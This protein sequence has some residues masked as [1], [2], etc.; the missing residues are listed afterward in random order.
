MLDGRLFLDLWLMDD[1]SAGHYHAY[2]PQRSEVIK[3]IALG[4][5]KVGTFSDLDSPGRTVYTGKLRVDLCCGV[6]RIR[7]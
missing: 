3:G 5:D 6:Q 4:Y 7:I 1:M 2:V